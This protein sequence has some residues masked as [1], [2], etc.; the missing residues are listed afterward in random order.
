MMLI[1]T[2]TFSRIRISIIQLNLTGEVLSNDERVDF[3]PFARASHAPLSA[4]DVAKTDA[5]EVLWL[6]QVVGAQQV[7]SAAGRANPVLRETTFT[8][9]RIAPDDFALRL[10]EASA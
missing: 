9:F 7:V 5:R 3:A 4:A 2:R 1:I 8:N 10:A 6:P